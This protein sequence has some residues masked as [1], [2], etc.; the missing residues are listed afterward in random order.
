MTL[1]A[2]NTNAD[3]SNDDLSGAMS[4][5][6]LLAYDLVLEALLASSKGPAE[7]QVLHFWW[8]GARYLV[9]TTTPS[10][11]RQMR[12]FFDNTWVGKLQ[13]WV[14]VI[15][16]NCR[17]TWE[18]DYARLTPQKKIKKRDACEE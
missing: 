7:Q 15:L 1:D 12:D 3:L 11:L 16:A 18:W 2:M 14:E 6:T 4:T 13:P 9:V 17:D 8:V 5:E 10:C